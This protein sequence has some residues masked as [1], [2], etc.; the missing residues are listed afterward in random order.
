[1]KDSVKLAKFVGVVKVESVLPYVGFDYQEM[2]K[3]PQ[4]IK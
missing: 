3:Q 2:V 4:V 1:L